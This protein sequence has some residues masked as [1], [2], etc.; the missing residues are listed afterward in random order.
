MRIPASVREGPVALPALRPLPIVGCSE[1]AT[2]LPEAGYANSST[3][4]GSLAT[5]RSVSCLGR[6]E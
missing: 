2:I 4:A 6:W 5:R 3:A 1:R